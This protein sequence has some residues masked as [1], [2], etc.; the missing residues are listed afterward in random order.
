MFTRLFFP[1]LT[2]ILCT[3]ITLPALSAEGKEIKP[4]KEWKGSFPD[5]KDEPLMKVAPGNGSYIANQKD[6]EKLWKAW[7]PKEELPKIDFDKQ[8]VFVVSGQCADNQ[9]TGT[10]QLTGQGDLLFGHEVT[11][12]AGPGF[13]YRIWVVDLD[14]VKTIGGKPIDKE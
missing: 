7:R 1:L 8:I 5:E 3:S 10:F 14:G 12:R 4:V 13:V 2:L 9:I 6:W 11:D